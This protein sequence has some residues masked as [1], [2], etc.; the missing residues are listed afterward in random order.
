MLFN[1]QYCYDCCKET[2]HYNGKCGQCAAKENEKKHREHFAA[3]D[4][5]TLEERIRRLEKIDYN[6]IV[7][8]PWIEP[9]Y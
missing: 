9:T 1:T 7:N 8:P 2:G 5:M 6:H 3:L 4:S